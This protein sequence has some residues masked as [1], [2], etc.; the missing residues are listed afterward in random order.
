[1]KRKSKYTNDDIV[2]HLLSTQMLIGSIINE[3]DS[4]KIIDGH[5]V[6]TDWNKHTDEILKA[7]GLRK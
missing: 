2:K 5:A 3:L 6:I 4:K 1:M 7:K